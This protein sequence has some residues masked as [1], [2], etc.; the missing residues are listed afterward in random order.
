M[1]SI[2]SFSGSYVSKKNGQ[3]LEKMRWNVATSS[4]ATLRSWDLQTFVWE[5]LSRRLSHYSTKMVARHLLSKYL[6]ST[7]RVT[8]CDFFI[9]KNG[10]FWDQMSRQF[11]A[12]WNV[13][14]LGVLWL[15]LTFF[16][17]FWQ[18]P[19]GRPH[20]ELPSVTLSLIHI[21]RCRRSTLCRSRWSP[22]H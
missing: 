20:T 15:V 4:L 17:Y 13:N 5:L 12:C 16:G 2:L 19:S 21:W 18:F 22:Y 11:F 9:A 6:L 10:Y 8:R 7:T 3:K 14:F 1:R